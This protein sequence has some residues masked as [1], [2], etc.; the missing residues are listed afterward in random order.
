MSSRQL[1]SKVKV[2]FYE[3][4]APGWET[5]IVGPNYDTVYCDLDLEVADDD[6]LRDVVRAC[7]NRW[8]RGL[9]CAVD[10]EDLQRLEW[11]R[12]GYIQKQENQL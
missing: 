1:P 12:E 3:F 6:T 4:S 5:Q 8:G 11:K 10:N 9:L 7:Y 2:E